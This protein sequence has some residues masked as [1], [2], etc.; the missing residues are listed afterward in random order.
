MLKAKTILIKL[1]STGDPLEDPNTISIA[2]NR[3]PI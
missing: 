1:S 2:F 3:V